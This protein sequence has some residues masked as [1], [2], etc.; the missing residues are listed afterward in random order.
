MPL[1]MVIY[2]DA[3]NFMNVFISHSCIY[4]CVCISVG[5]HVPKCACQDHKTTCRT[6][7]LN[8]GH[9]T[10]QHSL[11]LL[12]YLA[13]PWMCFLFSPYITYLD[14]ISKNIFLC[15]NCLFF[16]TNVLW[17]LYSGTGLPAPKIQITKKIFT[18]K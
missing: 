7:G 12:S 1:L 13:G 3:L 8:S 9:Q 5:V 11:Y 6:Q 10:W 18:Y 16:C 4:L 14:S 2:F 17:P 15:V